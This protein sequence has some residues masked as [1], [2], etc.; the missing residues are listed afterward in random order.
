MIAFQNE[1]GFYREEISKEDDTISTLLIPEH[2]MDDF[3][4]KIGKRNGN[5]TIYLRSLLRRFRSITH[6]GLLPEPGKIK[7]EYQRKKLNLNKVNFR[8]RNKDWVELGELALA[9][10][11]SRCWV[12]VYLLKLDLLG[13]WRVLVETRMNKIVPTFPTLELLIFW[14]LERFMGTFARGYCVRV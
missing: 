14:K 11:K 6:T 7:T 5:I 13:L 10:G 1:N 9:F 4:L 2:L 12:F 8:P 3:L